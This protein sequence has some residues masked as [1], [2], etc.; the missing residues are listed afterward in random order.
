MSWTSVCISN[1]PSKLWNQLAA[2]RKVRRVLLE[3]RRH[4]LL[5]ER[6]GKFMHQRGYLV[7]DPE[8]L[9][10]IEENEEVCSHAGAAITCFPGDVTSSFPDL[11]PVSASD[12][13][14]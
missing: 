13:R 14:M 10:L 3:S 1:S 2:E 8:V 6:K 11:A 4:Q 9:R 5:R 7:A 12:E